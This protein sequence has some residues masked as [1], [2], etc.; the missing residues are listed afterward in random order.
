MSTDSIIDFTVQ[1]ERLVVS[2]NTKELNLF[3]IDEINNEYTGYLKKT[4][5]KFDSIVFVMN[6]INAVDSS[7]V[8][9]LVRT[10]LHAKR[11]KRRFI[12]KDIPDTLQK[13]LNFAN[14]LTDFE[15]E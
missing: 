10:H 14:L 9:F 11:N 13:T 5:E 4:R 12:L 15:V 1:N 6:T 7:S 2:F 3:N 8:A